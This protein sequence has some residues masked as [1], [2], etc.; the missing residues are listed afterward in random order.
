[1]NGL[2]S[3]SRCH[4][5]RLRLP[6]LMAV[7]A[8][9]S[10]GLWVSLPLW[11]PTAK[12]YAQTASEAALQRHSKAASEAMRRHDYAAAER[13]YL[14]L[15][16]LAPHVAE[17]RS[18]LGLAYYLQKKYDLAAEQFERAL[19][20]NRSLYYPNYLLARIRRPQGR[21]REAVS[22]L[23]HALSLQP[24]SSEARRE[25]AANYF[26]LKEFRR[27]IQAHQL[28]LD[29]KPHDMETLYDLG[30]VYM[31]L[32]QG[33]FDRV[34][35]LPESPFSSLIRARHYTTASEWNSS[36]QER[37]RQL[38]RIECRGA[39]EA[40]PHLPEVRVKL[41]ELEL[42]EQNWEE[43]AEL[44][45]AELDVDAS[46][47]LARFGLAQAFFH[48]QNLDATVSYLNEAARIRPEF[49]DPLPPFPV[50]LPREKLTVVDSKIG[51]T[52]GVGNFGGAFLRAVVAD[53][54]GD[55]RQKVA[56][57]KA[58]RE[59][60]AGIRSQVQAARPAVPTGAEETKQM[61][62]QLLR[63]KR[64]E[65][66]TDLLLPLL[67]KTN[68][69][70]EVALTVTRALLL[71]KKYDSAA[72]LLEPYAAH[73]EDDPE[74]Y[75]LLGLSY[76]NAAE[77][78]IQ[79]MIDT[80]PQSYSLRQ[81]MGDTYLAQGRYEAAAK[82][83]QAALDLQPDNSDLLISLGDVYVRQMKYP[84]AAECFRRSVESD[85]RNAL[86]QLK[87]GDSLLLERK[88]EQAIPH[89]RAAL[90]L[91]SS[92][93]RA[94]AILGKALGMLDRFEDAVRELEFASD[95]D[96]DGSLHYQLG[97]FYSKLGQKEKAVAALK[98]SQ[99]LRRQSLR[100]QQ[101]QVVGTDQGAGEKKE[102]SKSLP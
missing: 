40:A 83:Y 54:L 36:Q 80:D 29:N 43:A 31:N 60:L 98:K 91:D 51:E 38:A 81:L 101:L 86:A 87:L 63:Q 9:M 68:D 16:R 13:E 58:A 12:A 48:L 41:A 56:A 30:L 27:A 50:S 102:E 19:R 64:Y 70:P 37:W 94:R 26:E 18:N 47:Y 21:F 100:K 85:P 92:L 57:R 62:V 24:A 73:R 28:N 71:M 1:M 96:E 3:V 44:F 45:E 53:E 20:L 46:S 77:K 10:F 74:L 52:A 17:V 99:E 14:A 79:V 82:E 93:V 75:Y 76:Q 88:A 25:L 39:L 69:A 95:L 59:A 65:A 35:E 15:V 49:F 6:A 89:L 33:S 90:D 84:Q 42:K 22:L 97:T 78:N 61:G 11:L 2:N 67:R 66:G 5:S 72:Q 23:E 34:A 55:A 8:L 4:G 7:H 32:A